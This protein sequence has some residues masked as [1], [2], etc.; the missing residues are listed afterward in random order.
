MLHVYVPDVMETFN[1]AITAGCQAIEQPTTRPGDPD[2]RGMFSDFAGNCWA[3]G[4]QM[5]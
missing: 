4:T 2:K 3:I 1:K 5:A